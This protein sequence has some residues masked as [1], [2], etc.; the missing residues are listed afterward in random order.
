ML[1]EALVVVSPDPRQ[2]RVALNDALDAL[3]KFDDRKS[4]VIELRFCWWAEASTRC[5][6]DACLGRCSEARLAAPEGVSVARNEEGLIT[7]NYDE[8]L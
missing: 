2:D 1:D 3:A 8:A 6:C 5:L 4:R 7:S